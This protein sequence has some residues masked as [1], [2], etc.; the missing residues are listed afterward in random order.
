MTYRKRMRLKEYDYSLPGYYYVTVSAQNGQEWFGEVTDGEMVLGMP[1]RI[2]EMSWRE[3]PNHFDNVELDEFVVMPNH[4]HG[5]IIIKKEIVGDRHACPLRRQY[6]L[7]PVI[8]GGF[9]SAVSRQMHVSK[10]AGFRWQRSFYDRVLRGEKELKAIR[11]YIRNNPQQW[12]LD[13][14]NGA[15]C[16][17]G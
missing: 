14:E 2:V 1:G 6:Q 8:I 17:S 7:L 4:L 11:E 13:A 15:R 12:D 10:I 5:I 3:I 16:L 9:K